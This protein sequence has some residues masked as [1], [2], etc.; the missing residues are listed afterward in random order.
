VKRVAGAALA[1]A[2]R[3]P[4][5]PLAAPDAGTQEVDDLI[6]AFNSLMT[7]LEAHERAQG[8]FASD[9]SHELHSLASAMQTAADALERGADTIDEASRRRLVAGLVSHTR[10]LN[11]LASDLLELARWE[12]GRLQIELEHLDAADLVHGVLDEWVAE[13]ERRTVSL[14]VDV[15]GE[16]P[17]IHGDPVRL[18]QALG[19]LVENALKYAGSGGYI[20]IEVR[21]DLRDGVCEIVVQDSGPGI[22]EES[23]PRVFD[24][25]YRVEGRAAGGPGGMGLGLAI[26]RGIARAH[27]GDVSAER[28]SNVGARFVLRLP[29]VPAPSGAP[30]AVADPR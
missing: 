10:R 23:L 7:Q 2:D 30:E 24:R 19:N 4:V 6:R 29:I 11:R 26:A 21:S 25:Y 16:G 12:G 15:P 8:E 3:R 18:A 17:P 27:G 22:S 5:S 20:R 9:V 1:L 28:V 13:A 14:Q